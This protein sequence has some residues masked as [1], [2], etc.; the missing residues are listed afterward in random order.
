VIL[1]IA[2]AKQVLRLVAL[3]PPKS[4][5]CTSVP[6]I[7]DSV[8]FFQRFVFADLGA[9]SNKERRSLEYF[10]QRTAPQLAG[11]F[12][13]QL[14]DVALLQAA[15]QVPSLR[16]ALIA[17]GSIHERFEAEDPSIFRSNTDREQGGF[18]LQQ[19]I[20]AIRGLTDPLVRQ[21]ELSLD[22]ALM[23][24]ILFTCFEVS[25]FL[26]AMILL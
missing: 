18:A 3:L 10:Q 25:P 19:Y 9:L 20:K 14:W 13:S 26:I 23:S 16:H 21:R 2:A 8:P 17:V 12:A 5:V 1:E 24:C 4:E 11:Y 7:N 6:A 22:V 15:N